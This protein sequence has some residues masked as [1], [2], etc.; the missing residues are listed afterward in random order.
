[1]Q[2]VIDI[3]EGVKNAFEHEE[4]WT[5]LLCAEM[6]EALRQGTPLPK[7]H[8]RLKDIDKFPV[9]EIERMEYNYECGENE[10][11]SEEIVYLDD[12][13]N[14]ETIIEADKEEENGSM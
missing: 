13:I 2:I 4:Q 14:A 10:C 12:I 6:R 9:N 7:G 1:M 5:A 8:G 11:H 3:P